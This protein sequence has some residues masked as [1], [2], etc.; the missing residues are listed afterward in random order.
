MA[1]FTVAT[2]SAKLLRGI[3]TATPLCPEFSSIVITLPH[4]D[5][6]AH[7]PCTNIIFVPFDD[8]PC[9]PCGCI[10]ALFCCELATPKYVEDTR[11]VI[12]ATL[13]HNRTE[14]FAL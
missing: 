4:E 12:I 2:S 14:T 7:P 1:R 8:I 11:H 5:P 6:S 10:N 3:L 9:T 13:K